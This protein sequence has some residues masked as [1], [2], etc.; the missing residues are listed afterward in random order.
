M[1]LIY[2]TNFLCHPRLTNFCLISPNSRNTNTQA[3]RAK[4]SLLFLLTFAPFLQLSI[5]F[6]PCRCISDI[7]L[8]FQNVNPCPTPSK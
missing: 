1:N 8:T 3:V 4:P 6:Y 7:L 5:L 2:L